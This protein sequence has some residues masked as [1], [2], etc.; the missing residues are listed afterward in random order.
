MVPA[1]QHGPVGNVRNPIAVT[2]IGLICFIYALFVV[3]SELNELKAFRQKDDFNPVLT[4]LLWIFFVWGMPAKVLEAK[5]MAGIPNPTVS[6]PILYFLL[7]P[8]FLTQDLNEIWQAAGGQ[9]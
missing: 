6:S 1:G 7:G 8:Y 3:F 9:R 4:V 5:Q 2:L